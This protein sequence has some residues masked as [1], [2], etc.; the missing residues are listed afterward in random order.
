VLA[1]GSVELLHQGLCLL[2][3]SYTFDMHFWAPIVLLSALF[4]TSALSAQQ[5]FVLRLPDAQ[6]TADRVLR[7]DGDTY[8]LG[9]WRS[10][11]TVAL[12]DTLLKIEG[13]ISFTEKANDFTTIV[14]EYHQSIPVEA[15]ARCRHCSVTLDETQGSVSGLNIGARGYRWFKGQGLVR[16]ARIQTDIFGTDAGNIGGTI[17][18]API[19]V[20]VDCS[21]AHAKTNSIAPIYAAHADPD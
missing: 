21:I 9:D 1:L 18:F 13:K 8:G 6:L 3:W 2:T 12:V 19:R 11:F 5:T 4:L 15:L 20:L 7:G 17:Q 16:R 14:G 10:S